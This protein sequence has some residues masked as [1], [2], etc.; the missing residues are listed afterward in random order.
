M[1]ALEGDEVETSDGGVVLNPGAIWVEGDN[2]EKS[3]D[4]N[5]YGPI[6]LGLVVGKASHVIWPPGGLVTYVQGVPI[7]Q[8]YGST[9]S[10]EWPQEVDLERFSYKTPNFP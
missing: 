1:I 7:L 5:N 10:G 8:K 9:K 3:I 2:A 4:S 6:C